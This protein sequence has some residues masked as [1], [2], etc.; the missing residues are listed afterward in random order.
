ML[1]KDD[2]AMETKI[3]RLEKQIALLQEDKQVLQSQVK[4]TVAAAH[5]VIVAQ[6]LLQSLLYNSP[7]G[8]IILNQNHQIETFNRSA[9]KLFGYRE[10]D[11]Y[12][13]SIDNLTL[14]EL[15]EGFQGNIARFL[16]QSSHLSINQHIFGLTKQ[17]ARIPLR[18]SVS[19]IKGNDAMLFDESDENENSADIDALLCYVFD[20][21][22]EL[23]QIKNM[24]KQALFMQQASIKF[25]QAQEKA[26]RANQLKTEFLANISH[27]LR[28]PMQ[29]ILGFADRG[30]SKIDSGNK[31]VQLK[32]FNNIKKG[33][34]RLLTLL[35]DLLDLSK[36][37]AGKIDL[38]CEQLD[39]RDAVHESIQ[40]V[41]SLAQQKSLEINVQ[42]ANC[43]TSAYFDF[44]KILQVLRNLLSNAIKFTPDGGGITLYFTETAL[45]AENEQ[46][47]SEQQF[48]ALALTVADSGVGIPKAEL[49]TVFDKFAQSS[50]T[51][52]GGGGTGLGL[53][54]CKEIMHIHRGDIS[55]FSEE[56][57]GSQ[58]TIILPKKP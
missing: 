48:N 23:Q 13:Q 1:E 35:N 42:P 45:S 31:E 22:K 40:E 14:F 25:Q 27:E 28:T 24:K 10:V 53:A 34:S 18:V 37:E 56:D 30:I 26:E 8:I 2:Q 52:T 39:L 33:G 41:A 36:L 6:G 7:D 12:S 51:R 21:S 3:K 43:P 57:K 47:H 9:E 20:I 11:L 19:E 29:A 4:E 32:Y 44:H 5:S 58:F 17:G 55:V 46:D 50:K 38:V 15:P 49:N 16:I 54:I